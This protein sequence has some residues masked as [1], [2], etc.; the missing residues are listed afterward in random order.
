VNTQKDAENLCDAMT[1]RGFDVSFIHGTMDS[2]DRKRI[3]DSFREGKIR[4]LIA[5]DLIGRGIDVQ[6]ISLVIN[7]QLPVQHSN[8][9]HRIGRSGR[10][11]RK[12]ASI[13][14]ID[15]REMRQQEEIEAFY[16]RKIAVLPMDLNIYN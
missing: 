11:G 2:K 8:Y 1:G 4:V 7:F 3:M 5:T 16:G 13:N 6:Q 12:G 15:K 10:Y 9:I 14:I